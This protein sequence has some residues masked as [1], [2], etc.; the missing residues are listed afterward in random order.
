LI[1]DTSPLIFLAKSNWLGRVLQVER[2][3]TTIFTVDEIKEPLRLG[4]SLEEVRAKDIERVLKAVEEGE[5]V[6]RE[7][8]EEEVKA[9]AERWRRGRGEVATYLLQKTCE[10]CGVIVLAN[11]RAEA[12]LREEGANVIDLVDLGYVLVDR[13]AIKVEETIDFLLAIQRAGYRTRRVS[14]LISRLRP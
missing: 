4:I 12:K 8:D 10:E 14:R 7:V 11:E 3:Y 5:I 13:G 2:A 6:V 9:L 1:F